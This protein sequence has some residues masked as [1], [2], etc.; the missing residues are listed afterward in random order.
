LPPQAHGNSLTLPLGIEIPPHPGETVC[1]TVTVLGNGQ[2]RFVVPV[3]V[4]VADQPSAPKEKERTPSN[5]LLWSIAAG[6][7]VLALILAI[8]LVVRHPHANLVD[9]PDEGSVG[10]PVQPGPVDPP[11]PPEPNVD[12]WWDAIPDTT[13][14]ASV[15][16][17]KKA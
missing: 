4:T 9:S 1:A 11:K 3:S 13:L 10:L 7:V 8:T 5:R 14:T 2:Q 15:K 6:V 17:L 16:E 12:R